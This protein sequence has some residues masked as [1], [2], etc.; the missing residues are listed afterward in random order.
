MVGRIMVLIY[1]TAWLA[2]PFLTFPYAPTHRVRPPFILSSIYE[3][4]AKCSSQIYEYNG[5]ELFRHSSIDL[6]EFRWT[7]FSYRSC[8][9]RVIGI[10]LFSSSREITRNEMKFYVNSFTVRY[11][12]F[13]INIFSSYMSERIIRIRNVNTNHRVYFRILLLLYSSLETFA[14]FFNPSTNQRTLRTKCSS[15]SVSQWLDDIFSGNSN[16]IVL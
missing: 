11:I 2:I 15:F 3:F 9:L 14:M 16:V 7:A 6:F 10:P 4:A 5:L 8:Q 1:A 13:N 12:K